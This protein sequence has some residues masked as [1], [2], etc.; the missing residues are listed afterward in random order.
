VVKPLRSRRSRASSRCPRSAGSSS[1]ATRSPTRRRSPI[2]PVERHELTKAIFQG[3]AG[4]SD[5]K[6]SDR[7]I[8]SALESMPS[9]VP[10]AHRRHRG[11]C[12]QHR[13]QWRNLPP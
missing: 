7:P 13:P 2:P 4:P 6:L 9:V 3:V 8:A 1:A 5:A 12:R 10:W 11:A